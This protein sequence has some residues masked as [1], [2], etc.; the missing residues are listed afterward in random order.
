MKYED[1]E[2]D[3]DHLDEGEFSRTALNA[4]ADL[5]THPEREALAHL[6][7]MVA[8]VVFLIGLGLLLCLPVIVNNIW[9]G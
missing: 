6:L 4:T 1:I 8:L 7:N 9:H 2:I 5:K 3:M